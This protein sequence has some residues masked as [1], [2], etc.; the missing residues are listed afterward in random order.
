MQTMRYYGE[1][2]DIK[3][4]FSLSPGISK[5]DKTQGAGDKAPNSR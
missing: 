3:S 1:S 4:L 5:A 2:S